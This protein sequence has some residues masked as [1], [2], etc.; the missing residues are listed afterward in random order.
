MNHPILRKTACLLAF[1]AVTAV[2]LALCGF[3]LTDDVHSYS[4]VMLQELYAQAGQID[5]LFLGS[6]HCYRSVDPDAVN[7]QLGVHSFN[8]GTSQQLPDGSY[9]LL[10]EA[11]AEND[12]ET[13][14]LEMYY[15]GYNS[16]SSAAVPMACYLI[17]DYLRPTSLNRYRY[18]WE[19]GGPAALADLLLPARH[20]IADPGELTGLWRAKLTDGYEPG[21]YRYVT[22]LD[23]GEA[24]YGNG[25]VYTW[26]TPGY[27]F[28][29]VMNLDAEAPL[30][31]FG[32]E[33]LTRIADFCTERGIRLVLFTAPLPGAYAADTDNYQAYVDAVRAFA[34][35]YGYE[36]WDFT[37]YRD[38]T[39]LDMQ[40]EDFADAHHLNG[41]GAE[42]FTAVLCEVIA[43]RAAG[44]AVTPLFYDTLAEKLLYA[45]DA[46]VGYSG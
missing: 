17:A 44:E 1:A 11:A 19:M 22:Y 37:L 32:W 43:R 45:P 16:E 27:G 36:Y 23:E 20:T 25:F 7:G 30:S 18:L 42:K 15:T 8:A 4:R 10:R 33:Y 29:T 46:T 40:V 35:G 13:V 31:D 5:T 9:Y 24:Y 14:Y 6:S 38:N 12:L 2:L 3:L 28:N 39:A 26:G 21:N 41:Q 34:A